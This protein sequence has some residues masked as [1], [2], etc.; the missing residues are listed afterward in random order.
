M[1][2]TILT[3]VVISA[4]CFAGGCGSKG[5]GN[6]DPLPP[7]P[8]V[9]RPAPNPDDPSAN[10]DEPATNPDRPGSTSSGSTDV[11]NG[12]GGSGGRKGNGGATGTQS[13]SDVCANLGDCADTC[14]Q[15]CSDASGQVPATCG[16]LAA[17]ARNCALQAGI[18]CQ[19][20]KIAVN[21]GACQS[22]LSAFANCALAAANGM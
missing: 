6:G 17:A 5:D 12:G 20:G 18:T 13:C 7:A 4:A 1:M 9:E 8:G 19:S 22:E 2:R 3:G 14:A 10:P 21:G 15:F 11:T 16:A